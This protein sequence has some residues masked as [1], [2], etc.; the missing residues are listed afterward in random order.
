MTAKNKDAYFLSG[1]SALL[2]LAAVAVLLCGSATAT[3]VYNT[4]V[5]PDDWTGSRSIGSGLEGTGAWGSNFSISWQIS[6]P[7]SGTFF[8]KYMVS[9]SVGAPSHVIFELSEGCASD[10][11]ECVWG[12]LVDE[13]EPEK[14]DFGTFSGAN[15]SN[16]NMPGSIYGVKIDRPSEADG[17][18]FSFYS[19][20]MPVWGN[21][22]AKDGKAD[23]GGDWNAVWNLGL[24][25]DYSGSGE[26]IHF[27]ARPDTVGMPPEIPEPGTM[28]ML[29]AGLLA[30]GLL[31]R[32]A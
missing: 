32:R 2:G 26:I 24:T 11:A 31:R 17:Y 23:G 27:I 9:W 14:V 12:F 13:E 19:D 18:V 29:G 10:T 21:F 22:Y 8:Y 3:P 1:R 20:R 5:L 6:Q 15:P 30:I 4:D 7:S 25:S 28:V 16:P